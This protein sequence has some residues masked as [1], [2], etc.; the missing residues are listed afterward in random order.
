VIERVWEWRFAA[1]PEVLW[2][3]LADTAR[4]NE[5]IGL[6]RYTIEE[7]AQ[8][9]GS[10]RR[11]GSVHRFGMTL[12]WEEGVPEWVAPRRFRHERR[13]NSGP[14]RRAATEIVIDPVVDPGSA[15]GADGGSRV[16]YRLRLEPRSLAVEAVLRLGPVE[17][18]GRVL[19]R[20]FREAA[21]FAIE[22]RDR[23]LWTMPVSL[24]AKVRERIGH[25]AQAV[26]AQGFAAARRLA[27]HLLE[28]QNSELERMR[29]RVLARQWGIDPRAVIETCLAAAREGLLVLRWDLICPRCHGA[30]AAVSSLDELPEGAHCPSCNMPFDRDF[31]RNVE[32]T[33]DPADDI[34]PI[35]GGTYC[36]ASPLATRHIKIQQRLRAGSFAVIDADLPPGDYRVRTIEAGGATDFQ[37][38]D[39]RLPEIV[40][41]DADPVLG[42]GWHRGVLHAH[43][44]TA[45]DRTLVIEDRRWASEALTAHEVTT[46]QAFRDL[47]ADAVLRPGDRVEIR[48]VAF[49]FTDIKGST[50]LYNRVGDARAYGWVREHFAVLA[51]AVRQH[52]GAVVKT[53]GDAVMAAFSN[54]LDALAAAVAI[55]DDIAEFNRSLA[56]PDEHGELAIIVKLGLHCGPCIAVTLNDRLDY[57]GRTVNLAARLEAES[58]GGDIVLS[59]AMLAEPGLREALARLRPA[60]ETVLLKGFADPVRLYRVPPPDAT[61][62]RPRLPLAG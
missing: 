53:I 21:Q 28:A 34:R 4:F 12:T 56:A 18:F 52:D 33:F 30:K 24:P 42:E 60:E 39:G 11:T 61:G 37:V 40:L 58:S 35:G 62:L 50:D 32:V 25:R 16:C 57:F 6:P 43:N 31:S 15:A 45:V 23:G 14:L 55:R 48:R 26:A 36:L 1:A 51:R 54:P 13:F 59:E 46:M 17:H 2:P 29:P 8:P 41:G 20:L 3:V 5:A 47:F 10:V 7:A 22:G 38:A 19:D 27:E 49:L 9:D 44:A